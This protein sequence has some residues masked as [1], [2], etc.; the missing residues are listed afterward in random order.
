VTRRANLALQRTTGI[1]AL[2]LVRPIPVATE[3]SP[4]QVAKPTG[5][6]TRLREMRGTMLGEVNRLNQQI[7]VIDRLLNEFDP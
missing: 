6:L 4:A 3:A 2:R 1:P 7:E 5:I